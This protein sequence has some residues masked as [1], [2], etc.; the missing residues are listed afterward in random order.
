MLERMARAAL[1]AVVGDARLKPNDP[2]IDIAR[3]V[4]RRLVDEG[5]RVLT[6]GLGGVMEA[7]SAGAHES[8]RYVPGCVIGLLPGH[9]PAAANPHVDVAIPTRLDLARNTIVA[10]ADAVI[11]VGGG[12]GTLS[13][14]ALAWQFH[15][16]I[17]ALRVAGWSG[18]LADRRI[19]DR[20][21]YPDLP[22]DR[23]YGAGDAQE[24]VQ[25][26][27]EWLPR[28]QRRHRGV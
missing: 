2:R 15:R 8:Q 1:V 14:I 25:L 21:R 16:L 7:A 6:G 5:C 11:A 17:V 20:V 24:A 26:L 12:S 28:Y 9:D 23:V 4:G 19:D 22:E 27:I 10:H 13:E 18:E 3:D